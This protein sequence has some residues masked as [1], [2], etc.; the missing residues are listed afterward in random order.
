MMRIPKQRLLL[1][2]AVAARRAL[3]TA[4]NGSSV[5]AASSS[6]GGADDDLVPA[7]QNLTVKDA[8]ERF[9]GI[10]NFRQYPHAFPVTHSFKE[11][12][13]KYDAL[14]PKARETHD[15]VALAG[16]FAIAV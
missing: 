15:S 9:E 11:Y 8:F 3:T 13:Q 14:D 10:P 7:I 12:Q 4:S 5:T 6:G 2:R 16:L 1:Q